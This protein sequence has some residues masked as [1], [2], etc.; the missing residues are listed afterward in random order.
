[1]LHRASR[2][3][4]GRTAAVAMGSRRRASAAAA[5][6]RSE[7]NDQQPRGRIA[8]AGHRA[9]PIH[10]VAVGALLLERDLTAVVPQA[11][12][13]VAGNDLV[14]DEGKR[15]QLMRRKG[16]A[17]DKVGLKAFHRRSPGKYNEGL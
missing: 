5:S 4:R 1:M 16:S 6:G 2:R 3:H 14:V 9:S 8:E 7:T 13:S 11:W 17:E 12:T 15:R 10:L